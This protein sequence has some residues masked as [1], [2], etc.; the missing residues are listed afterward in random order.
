MN[1][2][3]GRF[4][5]PFKKALKARER[6]MDTADHSTISVPDVFPI[7]TAHYYCNLSQWTVFETDSPHRIRLLSPDLQG[8]I[9][10]NQSSQRKNHTQT[11][12]HTTEICYWPV[13]YSSRI[14]LAKQKDTRR[15]NKAVRHS[16]VV[17]LNDGK[18][19]QT[20]WSCTWILHETTA[21]TW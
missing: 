3:A 2:L 12:Y 7:Y 13:C 15:D 4:V 19:M 10:N 14:Q 21:C 9:S 1:G 16:H 20:S 18:L 8:S 6:R 17:T 11:V 5:Q